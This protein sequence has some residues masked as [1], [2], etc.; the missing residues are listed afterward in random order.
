[1]LPPTRTS[2]QGIAGS[3][4]PAI[5]GRKTGAYGARGGATR[6]EKVSMFIKVNPTTWDTKAIAS[7]IIGLGAQVLNDGCPSELK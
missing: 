6:K 4:T 7:S 3:A 5:A 1:M 2:S